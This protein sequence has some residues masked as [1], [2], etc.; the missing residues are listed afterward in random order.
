MFK[1][2]FASLFTPSNAESIIET[3][4]DA[5]YTK[6]EKAKDRLSLLKQ[7]E[8]FKVAQRA[9]AVI[10]SIPYVIAWMATFILSF[11]GVDVSTQTEMLKGDIGKINGIII[12]FYFMGGML[13]GAIGKMKKE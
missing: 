2:V 13:E 12:A 7:Y 1:K 9:L 3:V 10:Y 11:C 8:A 4:D 6:E 5:F